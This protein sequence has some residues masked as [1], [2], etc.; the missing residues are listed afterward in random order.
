MRA[1]EDFPQRS[2]ALCQC[3]EKKENRGRYSERCK[4]HCAHQFLH[5]CFLLMTIHPDD[6][7]HMSVIALWCLS[8]LDWRPRCRQGRQT[9]RLPIV[10]APIA[11]L[12]YCGSFVVP[13]LD[14]GRSLRRLWVW[15]YVDHGTQHMFWAEAAENS[16]DWEKDSDM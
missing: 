1:C 14:L 15:H 16:Q 9:N 7:V 4:P 11:L 6:Y 3:R 12:R 5:D 2:V 8:H 10:I 13:C